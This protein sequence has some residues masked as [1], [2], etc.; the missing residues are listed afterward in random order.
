MGQTLQSFGWQGSGGGASPAG[1]LVGKSFYFNAEKSVSNWASNTTIL[2]PVEPAGS[3]LNIGA[4]GSTGLTIQMND[5]AFPNISGSTF[6]K[7]HA[8]GQFQNNGTFTSATARFRV[9]SGTASNDDTSVTF[10]FANSD[11]FSLSTTSDGLTLFD[12]EVDLTGEANQLLIFG[13]GLVSS[14]YSSGTAT[15]RAGLTISFS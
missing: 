1:S 6:S 5:Y 9:G 4:S 11:F 7:I 13:F 12:V 2:L 8:Q 3:W 15:L 14:S 10:T